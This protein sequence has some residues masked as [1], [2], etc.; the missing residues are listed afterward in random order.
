MRGQ[1]FLDLL[2]IGRVSNLPTVWS[3]MVTGFL[4]AWAFS[5]GQKAFIG[6]LPLLLL[7]PART[8]PFSI[9]GFLRLCCGP[10]A[11]AAAF[12]GK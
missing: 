10:A 12:A 5:G 9:P 8:L 3:N 2:A 11:A 4:L 7:R 6:A 1:R